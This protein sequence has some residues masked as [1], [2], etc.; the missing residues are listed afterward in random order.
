MKVEPTESEYSF[1][2]NNHPVTCCRCRTHTRT[3]THTHTHTHTSS[4]WEVK[5]YNCTFRISKKMYNLHV[6]FHKFQDYGR[7]RHHDLNRVRIWM[8]SGPTHLI[9]FSALFMLL[10]GLWIKKKSPNG[11]ICWARP[12][13]Y[14]FSVILTPKQHNIRQRN[15]KIRSGS[16]T[17]TYYLQK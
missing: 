10:F 8:Y 11:Q 9:L 3:H 16:T 4:I 6:V 15:Q 17:K 2:L 14:R 7:T 13:K 1:L 5:K 12:W